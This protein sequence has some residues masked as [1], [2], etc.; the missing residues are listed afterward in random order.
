LAGASRA[1]AGDWALRGAAGAGAG[2]EWAVQWLPIW[3]YPFAVGVDVRSLF[4]LP[5]CPLVS[6]ALPV[7]TR[8]EP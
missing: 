3:V 6:F 5:V 7:V 8:D 4:V 2:A 1:A